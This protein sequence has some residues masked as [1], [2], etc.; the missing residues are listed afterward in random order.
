MS[1]EVLS[2][3]PRGAFREANLLA[4]LGQSVYVKVPVVNSAG[5]SL[6]PTI[7]RLHASG[8]KVNATAV[9]TASQVDRLA[10]V[11]VHPHPA[12]VSV[13]AGRILDAG[14]D[15]SFVVRHAVETFAYCPEVKILWASYRSFSDVRKA[16]DVCCNI[17]TIP[18]EQLAKLQRTLGKDLHGYSVETAGMF[19]RDAESSGYTLEE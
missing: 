14:H 15:P 2:E 4:S 7:K 13:F 19:R 11:L 8:I 6:I 18:P 16:I 1:L 3:D 5:E 17:I 9:F 12:I 10:D